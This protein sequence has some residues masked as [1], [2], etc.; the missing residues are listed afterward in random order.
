M[1]DPDYGTG[2]LDIAQD[3]AIDEVLSADRFRQVQE[4]E[5]MVGVE[6]KDLF[7]DFNEMERMDEEEDMNR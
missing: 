3:W 5:R 2:R 6:E 1:E 4:S 7:R